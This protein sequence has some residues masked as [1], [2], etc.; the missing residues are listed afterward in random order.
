[1]NS[2]R[3][4]TRKQ[5]HR[6][7]HGLENVI[8]PFSPFNALAHLGLARVAVVSGDATKARKDYQDFLAM[9]KDAD[10]DLPI[11]VPAKKEYEQIK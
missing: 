3:R 2:I 1:M 7:I 9:Y 5:R 11:L 10:Q 6:L 8:E 4:A